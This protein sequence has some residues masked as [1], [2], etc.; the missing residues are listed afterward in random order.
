MREGLILQLLKQIMSQLHV[1]PA[2][3]AGRADSALAVCLH[4]YASV[5]LH[6]QKAPPL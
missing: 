2:T 4:Q 1:L 3:V 6:E 5:S